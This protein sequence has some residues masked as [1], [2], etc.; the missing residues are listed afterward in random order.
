MTRYY[1]KYR[2]TVTA[3]L[4]PLQM[5]RVLVSV[6]AVPGAELSWAMPCVPFAALEAGASSLPMVGAPIWI[7]F[8]GGDPD[9][10]IWSG[11]FWAEGQGPQPAP[12]GR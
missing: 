11:T 4:D 1:G 2:A 10:P 5:G 3:N 6:P 12:L 8:E 9:Y 7:E